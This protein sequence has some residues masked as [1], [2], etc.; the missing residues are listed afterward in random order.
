MIY[1]EAF[2]EDGRELIHSVFEQVLEIGHED[3]MDRF[4]LNAFCPNGRD[5]LIQKGSV[6]TISAL[7]NAGFVTHEFD[8]S[9]FIKSGGSVFCMK[10][11]TWA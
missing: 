6:D 10:L 1:P 4:A 9:E 3:A 8:T 2:T 11:Q 5:V 7:H